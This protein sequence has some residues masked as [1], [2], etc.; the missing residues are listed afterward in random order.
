MLRVGFEP[1]I[2]AFD[3]YKTSHALYRTSRHIVLLGLWNQGVTMDYLSENGGL[4]GWDRD[5]FNIK[6]DF[7]KIGGEDDDDNQ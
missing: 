1:T 4:V 5:G 3:R 7:K 2:P 6:T